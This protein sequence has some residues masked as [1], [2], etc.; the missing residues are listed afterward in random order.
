MEG[1]IHY[2]EGDKQ[3]NHLKPK[4][5]I[6]FPMKEVR[7]GN[8]A[9]KVFISY[10]HQD[11]SCARGIA[12]YL[13][14][15]GLKVWIDSKDLALGDRWAN[16]IETALSEADVLIGILSS[17]SLRRKEVLKEINFG[18]KRMKEEG[19]EK[20]RVFFVVIGQ[21]HPSWFKNDGS[22]DAIK[23]HLS[24]YQYINLSAYAEVTISAMKELLSAVQ[25]K[26]IE[27]SDRQLL[28]EKNDN[29]FINQN[30]QPEKAFDNRGNN[31][32]YKVYPAD[33]AP[34][35]VYPFALDNQWLPEEFYESGNALYIEFEKNGDNP[36]PGVAESVGY[37]RGVMDAQA[38]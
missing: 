30:S 26:G 32:Y 20:F 7:Q 1:A 33:L 38:K 18:L 3:I 17:S 10:S 27:E 12:R 22:S 37:L 11:G 21:L 6:P 19:S 2:N 16:N 35:A 28:I 31:I 4:R 14:R 25:R 23:E 5:E 9:E 36:H 29:G 15:H 24:Q 34:S 13:E 8:M